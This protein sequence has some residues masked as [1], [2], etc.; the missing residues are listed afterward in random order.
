VVA[1][2]SDPVHGPLIAIETQELQALVKEGSLTARWNHEHNGIEQID[3][4]S[5]PASGPLIGV[6]TESGRA[7][8]KE[9]SL[10]AA[11]NDEWN[12]ARGIVVGR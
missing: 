4:A 11:W 7:L 3:V 8:F 2:A 5:S 1:V 12:G 6:L 10:T 9:G